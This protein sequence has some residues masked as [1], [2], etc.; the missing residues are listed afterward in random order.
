MQL[1][2]EDRYTRAL[3]EQACENRLSRISLP[4]RNRRYGMEE[5]SG[6]DRHL[7]LSSERPGHAVAGFRNS[8]RVSAR[9][10]RQCAGRGQLPGG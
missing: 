7:R 5:L 3:L 9:C 6:C 2:F 8:Y 1:E 10:A 4:C